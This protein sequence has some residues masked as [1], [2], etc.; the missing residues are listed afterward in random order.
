MGPSCEE[1]F[2][3]KPPVKATPPTERGGPPTEVFGVEAPRGTRTLV[4]VYPNRRPGRGDDR[5]PFCKRPDI[6]DLLVDSRGEGNGG[7]ASLDL[8]GPSPDRVK[9]DR[10]RVVGLNPVRKGAGTVTLSNTFVSRQETH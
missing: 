7:R 9:V 6:P 1:P 4:G 8:G 2:E 3:P 5:I 10:R